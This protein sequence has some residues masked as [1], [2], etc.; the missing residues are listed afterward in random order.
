MNDD[1]SALDYV[2]NAT[3]VYILYLAGVAL[4]FTPVIG[5]VMAYFLRDE[6]DPWVQT[7]YRFQIRTFWIGCL[8]GFIVLLL[9]LVAIGLLLIPLVLVWY[10][11]RSVKGWI[12]LSKREPIADPESWLFG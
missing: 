7:H 1:L 10:I 12:A 5:V 3:I 6:A 2:R 4:A 9:S 11:V 8:Y